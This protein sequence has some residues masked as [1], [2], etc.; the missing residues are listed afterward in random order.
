MRRHASVLVS[1]SLAGKAHVAVHF[2][3]LIF[4]L[5]LCEEVR[6]ARSDSNRLSALFIPAVSLLGCLLVLL[7]ATLVSYRLLPLL[8]DIA[9]LRVRHVMI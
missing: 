8:L 6:I 1:A 3:L 7:N 5:L 9:V 2:E 4:F